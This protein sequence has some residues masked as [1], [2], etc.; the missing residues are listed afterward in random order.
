MSNNT[1]NTASKPYEKFSPANYPIAI[2]E[3]SAL[4]QGISHVAI[5]FKVE[6]IVSYLK[7]HCLKTDW[8]DANPSLTRM[9]TSGF[10][11]TSHLESLFESYRSNTFF[12][13]DLEN[14]I[15][16]HLLTKQ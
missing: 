4:S 2:H 16:K 8:I 3:L 6:I 14:Y 15:T 10:F 13:K 12:L 1:N 5:Y 11:K 7:N 9:V